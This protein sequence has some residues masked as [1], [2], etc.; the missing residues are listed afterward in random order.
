VS[1]YYRQHEMNAW[2]R[3]F[4]LNRHGT[5]FQIADAFFLAEQLCEGSERVDGYGLKETVLVF[6]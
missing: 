3:S 5:F 6:S 4:A 1:A 2:K